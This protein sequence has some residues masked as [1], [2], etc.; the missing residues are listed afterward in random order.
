MSFRDL[1]GWI[2][3]V[4]KIGQLSV[5]KGAH[6]NLEIGAIT[7]LVQCQPDKPAILFDEIPDYPP[8]YRVLTNSFGSVDRLA[9]TWG[10]PT[11]LPIKEFKEKL[12]QKYKS[13]QPIKPV[14]VAD[15]P[16]MENVLTGDQVD[17]F[18]F[19]APMWHEEDGGRYIGT[20]SVDITMDPEELWVNVGTYRVMVID[21]NHTGFFI[22]TGQHGRIQRDKY[23]SQN[24]P[25][26]VAVSCGHDPAIFMAGGAEFPYGIS[27]Y[28]YAGAIKGEPIEVIRGP[29]TGLPI[30][31][32]SELVLEGFAMPG[33]ARSEGPFGEWT[34][35][36]G[37]GSRTEP[38]IDVKAIYHRNHPIILGSPPGKPPTEHTLFMCIFRS[39]LI[40]DEL[41]KAG[42]PDVTGVW[43]HEPGN[44]HLF[45]VVGIKQRY[46]GH[47]KQAAMVAAF[48]HT[49]NFHGR[50][51]VVVDDDI[52]VTDLNEVLW[53]MCTRVDPIRD[54]DIIRDCRSTALDPII[55][56][57]EKG[58][59]S[60]AIINACRPIQW[61]DK[62]P[63]VVGASPELVEK[64]VAKWKD[65]I[66]GKG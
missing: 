46:P 24:R 23:L 39:M 21:K 64:T 62:F 7:E 57:D 3:E 61:I 47:A 1:R 51:I 27:E 12:R 32:H 25:M 41:A 14:L 35:Y 20:G 22:A 26:P 56:V 45:L 13:L 65:L 29:V 53:A 6:W 15:G 55:P 16:V 44:A 66:Y 33:E 9:V 8:G 54:I 42:V 63:K 11:G 28:E 19:P 43:T 2:Q 38:I 10:L 4:E 34:G 59:A 30:P 60:R 50:Y 17:L 58:L 5:A 52:D 36:Y 48:S 31:A 40:E 37:S 18:R 49:G